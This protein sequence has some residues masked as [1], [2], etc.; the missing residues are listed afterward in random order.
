MMT[1]EEQ[2][3]ACREVAEAI[4]WVA[5]KLDMKDYSVEEYDADRDNNGLSWEEFYSRWWW[6]SPDGQYVMHGPPGLFATTPDGA[7]AREQ[8]E[9]R[10]LS[11]GIELAPYKK[12]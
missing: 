11:K 10:L 4:G 2:R 7:Y 1:P 8:A 9:E 12:T 3:Q 5:P 6:K